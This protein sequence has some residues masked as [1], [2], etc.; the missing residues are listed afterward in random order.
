[1][2]EVSAGSG[3]A[4]QVLLDQGLTVIAI[5]I[6]SAMLRLARG[7]RDRVQADVRH[8]PLATGRAMAVVGLNAVP[9]WAELSR[10][11]AP[12]GSAGCLRRRCGGRNRLAPA[13]R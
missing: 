13:W 3:P 2:I 9:D 6:S 10:V 5:D 4:T 8:L 1:M 12:A 7:V 11:L